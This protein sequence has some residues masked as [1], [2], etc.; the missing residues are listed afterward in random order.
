MIKCLKHF[1]ILTDLGWVAWVGDGGGGAQVAV[2]VN[3]LCLEKL[4][5]STQVKINGKQTRVRKLAPLITAN[6]VKALIVV[7]FA[8]CPCVTIAVV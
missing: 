5:V 6:K 8:P 4:Y 3:E 1:N 7:S 2:R